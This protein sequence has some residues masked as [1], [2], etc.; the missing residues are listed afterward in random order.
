MW[1]RLHLQGKNCDISI[2]EVDFDELK[3]CQ[4]EKSEAETSQ[5]EIYILKLL[6]IYLFIYIKMSN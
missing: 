3:C 5:C 1:S 6:F 2:H 4:T